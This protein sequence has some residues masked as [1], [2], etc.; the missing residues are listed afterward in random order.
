MIAAPERIGRDMAAA[1][2]TLAE[3]QAALNAASAGA[4]A[5]YQ[6]LAAEAAPEAGPSPQAIAKARQDVATVGAAMA[7]VS[8]ATK[9]WVSCLDRSITAVEPSRRMRRAAGKV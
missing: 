9:A 5:S 4:V 1:L 3:R 7:G 8:R 6:A 2:D